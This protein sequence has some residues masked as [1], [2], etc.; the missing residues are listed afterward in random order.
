MSGNVRLL[1]NDA[2]AAK[3]VDSYNEVDI[4]LNQ[5]KIDL[6]KLKFSNSGIFFTT[7][8]VDKYAHDLI[9]SNELLL[10]NSN[11]VKSVWKNGIRTEDPDFIWDRFATGNQ[12]NIERF[13]D[14][15]GLPALLDCLNT[16]CEH[17][18]TG[19]EIGLNKCM[20]L[21]LLLTEN[22]PKNYKKVN[23]IKTLVSDEGKLN[24]YF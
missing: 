7:S 8:T 2:T 18:I 9:K 15:G 22:P 19:H 21:I 10:W 20:Q 6:E 24:P 4:S 13:Y 12:E 23:L 17:S 5:F 11:G 3:D 14:T 16:L 1:F